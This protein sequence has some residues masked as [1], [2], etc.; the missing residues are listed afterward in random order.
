MKKKR[1]IAA[2][3]LLAAS[4]IAAFVL[5]G[6]FLW[7]RGGKDAYIVIRLDGE[8]VG[9]YPLSDDTTIE[10]ADSGVVVRIENGRASVISSDC[11]D[12]VCMR[13]DAL[14][15]SSFDGAS[16]VCL[17]NRVSVIKQSG[18]KTESGADTIAG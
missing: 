10:V 6:V 18:S 8:T 2:D 12:K 1:L 15:E 11:P 5:L 9:M 16:V 13:T 17:P 14:D 3:I 4:L 7:R